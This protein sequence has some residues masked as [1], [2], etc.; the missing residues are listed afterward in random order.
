MLKYSTLDCTQD[1][2][3]DCVYNLSPQSSSHVSP[4]FPPEPN[5]TLSS[6]LVPDLPSVSDLLSWAQKSGYNEVTSYTV[7]NLANRLVIHLTEGKTGV[8]LLSI[9]D[10]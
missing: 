2:Y 6:T 10:N 7:A 4:P 3:L 5:L 1:V 9:Q 8:S